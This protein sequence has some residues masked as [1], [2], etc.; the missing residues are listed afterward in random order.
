MTLGAICPPPRCPHAACS[1][2]LLHFCNQP[3][4]VFHIA[5]LL[6][7]RSGY[8]KCSINVLQQNPKSSD[9]QKRTSTVYPQ[10]YIYFEVGFADQ[11]L[12]LERKKKT[13]KQ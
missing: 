8:T 2:V 5:A 3:T 7:S 9:R 10:I 12:I 4:D 11:E 1:S 13:V 6:T